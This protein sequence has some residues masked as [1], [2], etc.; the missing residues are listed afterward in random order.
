MH[1]LILSVLFLLL[2]YAALQAFLKASP[3]NL[4]RGVRKA[5]GVA[6][7][8]LAAFFAITGRLPIAAP[9]F[10]FALPLL[11][12]GFGGFNPF[13]GNANKTA[14]QKS[15]VRTETVEMELDHD[16]GGMDG[17]VL[18]GAFAK[19][20]LSAMKE[21]E[22]IALLNECSES[23]PQAAQLLEAYL[24]RNHPEWRGEETSSG[25][26]DSGRKAAGGGKMTVEEALEI[27]GLEPD[28]TRNDIR[29][30]HRTLMKKLHPDH[31]GSTYLAAK[32]NQAK[33]LLLGEGGAGASRPS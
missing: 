30:A 11:G 10:F 24:D 8:A 13:G 33:D 5:G 27:L 21:E 28:A 15:R 12:R 32:I 3:K 9:L 31:G 7:L 29:R 25:S 1:Y 14:G 22:L 19:T 2:L 16:T 6:L 18:K 17:T 20:R 23:D 26:K 4:A